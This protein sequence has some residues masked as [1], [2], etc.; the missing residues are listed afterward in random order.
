VS[1]FL[2]SRSQR[3]G[4]LAVAVVLAASVSTSFA[5]IPVGPVAPV[6]GSAGIG[7]PYFPVDGNGGIDVLHYDVHDSYDFGKGRLSGWTRLRVEATQQLRSFN[8]DLLL[9]VDKVEVN[10][11]RAAFERPSSHELQITPAAALGAGS[12]FSVVVHYRG[13]PGPISYL[14]ER[15][16]LANRDEVITMNEPHM[17]PWWFP[18]NDHPLDKAS[19]DIHITVPEDRKVVANGELVKRKVRGAKA[20][21]HWRAVEPMAPYLAFF[22]AG[23][24]ETH[25]GRYRGRPWYVAVSRQLPAGQRS[26]L[27]RLMKKSPSITYWLEQ[28]LGRYP[29][30]TTG[31]VVTSLPVN[32]ALENQTRPTY[33]AVSPSSVSLVVHELAH[34]WFGDSVSVE[35]WSDIWLN[36]GFAT[37]LEVRYAETH[38][39][40]DGATW[41]TRAYQSH[42]AT[43]D[44]WN[45]RISDPGPHRIFDGAVYDRGAMTLQALRKRVGEADFWKILRTWVSTRRHANGSVTD[46]RSLAETLSGEDLDAFFTAWLDTPSRP[47]DSP[48]N[49]L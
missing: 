31:G 11:V 18:A 44:F 16:W 6:A 25:K 23:E 3:V 30:S 36:E 35:R 24:F 49:G 40:G 48:A 34:Q 22:A 7:D 5:G 10:G 29:F 9:P 4:V 46:F 20:T 38:G 1:T 26:G 45:L 27:V 39:G 12:V 28:Q 41:L 47:A 33:P 42:P 21:T 32:F 2:V 37:F 15:N 17:A 13:K 43:D 8:L 19:F 14:G